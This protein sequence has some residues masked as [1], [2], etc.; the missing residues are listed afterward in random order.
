MI[1]EPPKGESFRNAVTN[2][3]QDLRRTGSAYKQILFNEI[4]VTV[5]PDSNID[6]I[7]TIYDLKH[8]L[9]RLKN[10]FGG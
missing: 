7:C 10:K 3:K 2:L 8:E 9:R 4:Y 6:D 5:S 1:Y